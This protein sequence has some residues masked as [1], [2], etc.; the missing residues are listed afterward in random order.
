MYLCVVV[1]GCCLFFCLCRFCSLIFGVSVQISLVHGDF[2]LNNNERLIFEA[3]GNFRSANF[4]WVLSY[5][6]EQDNSDIILSN[7]MVFITIYDKY[8]VIDMRLDNENFFQSD[9]NYTIS[10]T[11]TVSSNDIATTATSNR[12][13][14][15]MNDAPSNGSCVVSVTG[16]RDNSTTRNIIYALESLVV[17][18]CSNWEGND[19]PLRY[20]FSIDDGMLYFN[21]WQLNL[22]V[23]F[24]M[25]F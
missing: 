4:E 23:L 8:C 18:K 3:N 11:I 15:S 10:T 24:L 5:Q 7:S 9:T 12:L 16:D 17:V 21:I 6:Q 1:G 19:L 20:H 22:Y 2:R 13:S 25:T 14:M